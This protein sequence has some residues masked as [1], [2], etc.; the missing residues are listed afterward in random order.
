[1][2]TEDLSRSFMIVNTKYIFKKKVKTYL[3]VVGLVHSIFSELLKNTGHV[4][5]R[6][7]FIISDSISELSKD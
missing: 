3:L 5:T 4:T 6:I 1:M 2:G 7:S